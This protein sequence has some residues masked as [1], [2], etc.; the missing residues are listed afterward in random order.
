METVGRG[1]R[2]SLAEPQERPSSAGVQALAGAVGRRHA[3]ALG[4]LRGLPFGQPPFL[5]FSAMARSLAGL[6]DLPPSL[7]ICAYHFRTAGGGVSFAFIV[8]RLERPRHLDDSAGLV[9]NP[10]QSSPSSMI[11]MTGSAS[12]PGPHAA[13]SSTS[14]PDTAT[15]KCT[16]SVWLAPLIAHRKPISTS[17][18]RPLML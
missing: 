15:R 4:T 17:H 3:L 18:S 8:L 11:V 13:Q 1:K 10:V 12:S 16:R 14:L 7:P 9:S 2:D 6:L 5:A